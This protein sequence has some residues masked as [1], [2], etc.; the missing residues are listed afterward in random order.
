MS[1]PLSLGVI[2]PDKYAQGPDSAVIKL[3]FVKSQNQGIMV[4]LGRRRGIR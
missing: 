3:T 2:S 1:G 4:E